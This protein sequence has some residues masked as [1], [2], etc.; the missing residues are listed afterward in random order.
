MRWSRVL[1]AALAVACICIVTACS[2]QPST[3]KEEGGAAK[4]QVLPD[5]AMAV[6]ETS[7]GTMHC[8]LFPKVAPKNVSNFIGLAEG[9]KAWKHPLNGR[10]V[11]FHLYDGTV[12]HRVIP[13]FMIQGG[14]PAGNGAGGP[15]YSTP[16]EIKDVTFDRPGRMALANEGANTNGSQFFITE[17]PQP[18]LNGKFTIIGQCD[19]AT[20]TLVKKIARMPR[21]KAS[22]DRPFDPVKIMKVTIEKQ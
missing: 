22:N 20:V 15:G 4:E 7:M 8:E 5:K 1:S 14:D 2:Q 6:I 9:T 16:D 3:K 18:Y 21:D 13:G 11:H 17:A 19:P 10:T 12:F